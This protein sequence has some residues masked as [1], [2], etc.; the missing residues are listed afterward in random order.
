M[1]SFEHR[2]LNLTLTGAVTAF[3]ATSALAAPVMPDF[4]AADS[5]GDGMVSPE[6]FAAKGGHEKAFREADANRDNRL[7]ND[8]YVAAVANNDRMKAGKYM[9][10]AWI[11]TKVKSLLLKEEGIKGLGVNVETHRGTVQLSGW[12]NNE[13]QIAQAE[14]IALTVEGVTGV[15]ND[16]QIKR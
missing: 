3:M 10:D 8:E 12:V 13:A 4:K 14:K 11:T 15:R 1:K 7:S 2:I 6:E 16:L 9:D 5:N